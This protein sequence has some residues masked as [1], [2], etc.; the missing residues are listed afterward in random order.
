MNDEPT[1]I[2]IPPKNSTRI[3]RPGEHFIE[4]EVFYDDELH[5]A[6]GRCLDSGK[7]A[8]FMPE[9]IDAMI[10]LSHETS[11]IWETG[12][13]APSLKVTGKTEKGN[14]VAIYAH[15]PNELSFPKGIRRAIIGGLRHGA[16]KISWEEFDRLLNLEDNK[17]VFVVDHNKFSKT[18]LDYM[19]TKEA[20]K[21]PQTIPFLGGKE[22]A[23]AYLE[24]HA[25]VFCNKDEKIGT[26]N[27]DDL[28]DG[29]RGRLLYINGHGDMSSNYSVIDYVGRFLA[30]DKTLA[31]RSAQIISTPTLEQVLDIANDYAAPEK[32]E[33]LRKRL[34]ELYK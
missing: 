34:S 33:D 22:R 15:V 1:I 7:E 6:L 12:Y 31:K 26:W 20:L 27:C 18:D 28:D 4:A 29:P 13:S 16:V 10:A 17:T 21:H 5:V 9:I 14:A 32:R 30:V 24:R 8:L 19:P 2:R 11:S 23:E 3:P 25:Q